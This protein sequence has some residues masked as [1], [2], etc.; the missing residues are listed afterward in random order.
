LKADIVEEGE[1]K[2]GDRIINE[3]LQSIVTIYNNNQSELFKDL[4][5]TREMLSSP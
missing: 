5:G 3:E 2:V 1:K 4:F